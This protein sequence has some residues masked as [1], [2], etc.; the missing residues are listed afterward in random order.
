MAA[1]AMTMHDSSMTLIRLRE[2]EEEE[3]GQKEE[4]EEEEEDYEEEE[5]EEAKKGETV[6]HLASSA[7]ARSSSFS[8]P[9]HP[10]V[11]S[12]HDLVSLV[13]LNGL[14]PAQADAE[15]LRRVCRASRDAMAGPEAVACWLVNRHAADPAAALEAACRSSGDARVA[16][17][18]V[19]ALVRLDE[20][21]RTAARHEATRGRGA[22]G[23][24]EAH[25]R[26]ER[27]RILARGLRAAICNAR[28]AV[29]GLVAST[30]A[31]SLEEDEEAAAAAAGAGEAA[32]GGALARWAY[33]AAA[34]A[35]A[36]GGRRL[37]ALVRTFE[38]LAGCVRDAVDV[39]MAQDR[40]HDAVATVA[41]LRPVLAAV[42]N[43]AVVKGV[44]AECE[45]VCVRACLCARVARNWPVA[46]LRSALRTNASDVVHA[47]LDAAPPGFDAAASLSDLLLQLLR[48]PPP[49]R[50]GADAMRVLLRRLPPLPRDAATVALVLTC[51]HA[52]TLDAAGVVLDESEPLPDG[53]ALAVDGTVVVP[54]GLQVCDAGAPLQGALCAGRADIALRLLKR[55]AA[56]LTVGEQPVS[57]LYACSA[58][59]D[60][61]TLD[62]VWRAL[63]PGSGVRACHVHALLGQHR[64]AAGLMLSDL[65]AAT[66]R[67]GSEAARA[68]MLDRAG[69]CLTRLP[70]GPPPLTLLSPVWCEGMA[71]EEQ[72]EMRAASPL[73]ATAALFFFGDGEARA[74]GAALFDALLERLPSRLRKRAEMLW[75][76]MLMIAL[77]V[78]SAP[79]ILHVARK[80][81]ASPLRA[82]VVQQ[83]L[84]MAATA[85]HARTVRAL[86]HELGASPTMA[87]L[88]FAVM[89]GNAD[90][91][92]LLLDAAEG[93]PSPAGPPAAPP[94][95]ADGTLRAF[96]RGGGGGGGA[97]EGGADRH[98]ERLLHAA[99][100]DLL[101]ERRDARSVFRTVQLL[102]TRCRLR[103]Q[104]AA[105]R[106]AIV[107]CCTSVA[108]S[109]DV[110]RLLLEARPDLTAAAVRELCRSAV[111]EGW[112]EDRV[113]AA[114]GALDP[115]LRPLQLSLARLRPPRLRV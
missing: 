105:L 99:L 56:L 73:L 12:G 43:D 42:V 9:H 39:A 38:E 61:A 4:E 87:T 36:E 96:L 113:I 55:G 50:L 48:R 78:N 107:F 88:S 71:A 110:L 106:R 24:D 111:H 26:D 97:Q 51:R 44:A 8:S 22:H 83:C 82:T 59:G 103:P 108:G 64:H 27:G 112:D 3:M 10:R 63:Q 31:A 72:L 90:V 57:L 85:G 15:A 18:V 80:C 109:A 66:V 58:R 53:V 34:T 13:L 6:K 65:W 79:A 28:P 2:E 25:G 95:P 1:T 47:L 33:G 23:P 81:P 16:Q 74:D 5:E 84:H 49:E 68:Y 114:V 29:V 77:L 102:L 104:P 11:L 52:G 98:G 30:I 20:R 89:R 93:L 100:D 14:L 21:K 67:A 62:V 41:A 94:L 70:A 45:S 86:L 69:E 32:A 92:E 91:A 35:I 7:G 40:Q 46:A 37:D 75:S 115:R 101:R 17:A 19:L 76:V 60:A 54:P